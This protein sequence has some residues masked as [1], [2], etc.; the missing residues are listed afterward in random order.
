[1]CPC[2][3]I[4]AMPRRGLIYIGE[5]RLRRI[6][7]PFAPAQRRHFLRREAC[8]FAVKSALADGRNPLLLT[9]LSIEAID[10]RRTFG[11][12]LSVMSGQILLKQ[13]L[14][15]IRD[16]RGAVATSGHLIQEPKIA[17]S[18]LSLSTAKG[19]HPVLDTARRHR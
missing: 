4:A 15:D 13:L 16:A 6:G 8:P 1:M 12:R 3:G 5:R 14:G 9:R 18:I 17:A 10:G 19:S 11:H 2:K 7:G